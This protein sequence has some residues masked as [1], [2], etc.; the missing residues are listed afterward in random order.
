MSSSLEL[1]FEGENGYS[2]G[3]RAPFIAIKTVSGIKLAVAAIFRFG[4][5]SYSN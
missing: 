4:P 1:M 3:A 5:F 2:F